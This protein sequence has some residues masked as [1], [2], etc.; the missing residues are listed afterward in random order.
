MDVPPNWNSKTTTL[1][2]KPDSEPLGHQ[3]QGPTIA[4]HSLAV[5]PEH[6]R[7]G[8]ATILMKSYIQRIKDAAIAKRIALL[9]HGP[10]I[11]F[12]SKLG[13]SNRGRSHCEFGG[14]NWNNMVGH[15]SYPLFFCLPANTCLRYLNLVTMTTMT[16]LTYRGLLCC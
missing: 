16:E 15:Y 4:I 3:D 6:Q 7:K 5:L 10:L 13:F 12:Y 2:E 8:L 1:P 11:P 9:T 14:G